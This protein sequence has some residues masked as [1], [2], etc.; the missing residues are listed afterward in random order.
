MSFGCLRRTSARAISFK[1]RKQ[2]SMSFRAGAS[3]LTVDHST[4]SS[5]F[6]DWAGVPA[7]EG[8][9]KIWRTEHELRERDPWQT[10]D[11][12]VLPTHLSLRGNLMQLEESRIAR[13]IGLGGNQCIERFPKCVPLVTL[14]D[15]STH[16]RNEYA[17]RRLRMACGMAISL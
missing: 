8:A 7:E 11:D 4:T 17:K 5:S 2:H 6:A 10:A 15:I 16:Q 13:Q 9:G 14:E 12:L 1:H 3:Q